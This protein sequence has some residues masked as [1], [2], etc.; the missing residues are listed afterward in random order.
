MKIAWKPRD[1]LAPP[2]E[3]VLGKNV[4]SQI[5]K[6]S[7]WKFEFQSFSRFL[8]VARILDRQVVTDWF[9]GMHDWEDS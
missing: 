3:Q 6:D 5:A 9:P 8:E 7:E 2:W 4:Y 1:W